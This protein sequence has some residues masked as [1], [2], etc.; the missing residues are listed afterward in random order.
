[1]NCPFH[2]CTSLWNWTVQAF[3]H[4]YIWAE[5]LR[6]KRHCSCNFS[7][8]KTFYLN[9]LILYFWH[10][11]RLFCL[12]WPQSENVWCKSRG[13]RCFFTKFGSW[14]ERNHCRGTHAT[15]RFLGKSQWSKLNLES[16]GFIVLNCVI[17]AVICWCVLQHF[18]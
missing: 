5:I 4:E 11:L 14:Q 6:K 3:T 18:Q 17:I 1:M 12:P 9:I 10:L 15:T 2:S 8:N 16:V 7:F 13:A